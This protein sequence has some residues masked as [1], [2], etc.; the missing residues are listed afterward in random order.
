MFLS[1]L[2]FCEAFVGMCAL[3]LLTGKLIRYLC[4]THAH[5]NTLTC[6]SQF[7]IYSTHCISVE[8]GEEQNMLWLED[9]RSE[10]RTYGEY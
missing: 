9:S 8:L 10:S 7:C 2:N 3:V 1:Q 6:T 4:V 5:L